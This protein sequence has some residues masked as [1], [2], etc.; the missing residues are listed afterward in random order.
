MSDPEIVDRAT[1]LDARKALLAEE[2]AFTH[3]REELAA[4]RRALPAVRVERDYRFQSEVGE[5]GL[6]D[7]FDGKEQLAVYHFMFGPDWDEGC[8]S[9][10]FWA[11]NFQRLEIHLGARGTAFV[12][13]SSAPLE[14]LHAYRDRMGW[15]TR[16]V[17]AVGPDFG[18]DFGVTGYDDHPDRTAD[19]AEGYNYS[20]ERWAEEMPGLSTFGRAEDG[21]ILHSYGTFGRGLDSL[22]AAYHVLDMTPAG[23]HEDGLDF[24]MAWVR[25]RDQYEG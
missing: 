13:V 24:P 1:W 20:G 25:R 17:S 15:Q 19:H 7:L 18:Y 21:G 6:A 4:K 22:N 5:V 8:P 12:M 11:D 10:S 2:K 16:W 9:C 3:A 14:K 23:R